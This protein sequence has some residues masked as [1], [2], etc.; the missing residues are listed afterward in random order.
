MQKCHITKNSIAPMRLQ[1][2]MQLSEGA[3]LHF[4]YTLSLFRRLVHK[5]INK[6]FIIN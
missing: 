6:Q 2:E 5:C 3:K 4:K 1:K